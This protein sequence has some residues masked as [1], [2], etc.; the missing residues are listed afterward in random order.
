MVWIE[1]E[2]SETDEYIVSLP[3]EYAIVSVST[4]GEAPVVISKVEPCVTVNRIVDVPVVE[5]AVVVYV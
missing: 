4:S 3:P 1:V 2:V 5:T